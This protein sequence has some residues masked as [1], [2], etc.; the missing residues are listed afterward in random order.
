MPK[1]GFNKGQVEMEYRMSSGSDKIGEGMVIKEG[2]MNCRQ[3]L[4]GSKSTWL[5]N[6]K[7][8]VGHLVL[9]LAL[10]FVGAALVQPPE[11]TADSMVWRIKS[12]YGTRSRSNSILRTARLH[13]RAAT[14]P[15]T[16]TITKPTNII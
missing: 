13:G 9:A 2:K 14:G 12:N 4:Q 6:V 5:V 16:S 3:F 15:I 10:A 1:G 7:R 8:T 11:A